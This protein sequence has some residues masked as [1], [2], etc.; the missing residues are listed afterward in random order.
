MPAQSVQGANAD[1]PDMEPV[2]AHFDAFALQIGVGLL[3]DVAEMNADAKVDAA[4][5]R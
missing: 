4:F 1:T 5:G 2:H 3:N